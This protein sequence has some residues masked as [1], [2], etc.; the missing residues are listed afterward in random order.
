MEWI[1]FIKQSPLLVQ[2]FDFLSYCFKGMLTEM[3][4][5]GQY[6][7]KVSRWAHVCKTDAN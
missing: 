2:I 6:A 1:Q 4:M 5:S 3:Y 7:Y